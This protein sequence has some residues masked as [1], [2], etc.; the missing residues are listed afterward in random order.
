M[1]GGHY[2]E[3]CEFGKVHSQCRCPGPKTRRVVECNRPETHRTELVATPD[4]DELQQG[5]MPRYY[6]ERIGDKEGKHDDCFYFVLDPQHD[7]LARLALRLY[8]DF[9]EIKGY[10]KL[11]TVLRAKVA[12]IEAGETEE[13]PS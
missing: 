5:I 1:A 8:A 2:V 10:E 4:A 9:A 6:V 7:L 3:V 13:G 11:A 12:K